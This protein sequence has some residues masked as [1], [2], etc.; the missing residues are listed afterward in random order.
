M[1]NQNYAPRLWTD[2]ELDEVR[3]LRS[4]GVG[5]ADIARKI[6][7]NCSSVWVKFEKRTSRDLAGEP[8]VSQI[9]DAVYADRRRRSTLSRQTIISEICGDPLPGYSA[10]DRKTFG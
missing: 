4:A 1:R 3:K 9:P 2:A 8:L 10:A 5:Y 6:G 7:R